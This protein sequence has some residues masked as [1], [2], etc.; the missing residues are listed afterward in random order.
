MVVS[1]SLPMCQEGDFAFIYADIYLC[2]MCVIN[3]DNDY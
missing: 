2:F 1:G 3:F